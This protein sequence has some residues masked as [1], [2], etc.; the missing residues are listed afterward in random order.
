[1]DQTSPNSQLLKANARAVL[2]AVK[3]AG[4]LSRVREYRVDGIRGLVLHVLPSGT[5]SWYFHYDVTVGR[6][7]KRRKLKLGRHDELTLAGAADATERL[8]VEV[9]DGGDPAADKGKA[10]LAITFRE[11]AEERFRSGELLRP[12]TRQDYHYLLSK[13]VFP[14]IGEQPANAISRQQVISVL[15]RIA[16]RGATRRADTARAVV[17]SVYS[18]G[19]DR[20]LVPSNL[21]TGLRNRHDNQP[22]DV[23]ATEEVMRTLWTAMDIGDAAM[24]A[25]VVLITK[26]VLLTG[27]RRTEIGAVRKEQLELDVSSPVLEIPRGMAKNRQAH[28]VPLS[29]QACTLFEQALSLSHGSEFVF[30]GRRPG[31]HVCSRS[32][33]RAMSRTRQKLGISDITIHD[34]RRTVGTYLSKFGVPKDIRERILN[35][36]GKRK[37]SV[38]DGIY[39][40]YEYDDEKRAAI[41]LWADALDAIVGDGMVEIDGYHKRLVRRKGGGKVQIR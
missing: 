15:D 16:N 24:S 2:K 28:R 27:Q 26:L 3:G 38:T 23:V 21:A 19:V 39:N 9:R 4:A 36:G 7:R 14:D 1:M 29:P 8:R 40:C 31:A 13:D 5:A 25:S 17:S 33:S 22:R 6:R 12:G 37:A 34:L 41:E 32:V 10:R 20:G 11:L 18:F 35:H 30:P